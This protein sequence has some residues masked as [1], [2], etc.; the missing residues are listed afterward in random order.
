MTPCKTTS[1]HYQE[2]PHGALKLMSEGARAKFMIM[3]SELF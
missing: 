2:I 1:A 3:L